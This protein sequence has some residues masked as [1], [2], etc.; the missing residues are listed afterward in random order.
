VQAHEALARRYGEA[1]AAAIA[2]RRK[3]EEAERADATASTKALASGEPLPK[4]KAPPVADRL[5]EAEREVAAVTAL[6]TESALAALAELAPSAGQVSEQAD[7]RAAALEQEALDLLDQA[8]KA[9]TD[10]NLIRA[11]GSWAHE[12][13]LSGVVHPFS[14]RAGSDAGSGA[15]TEAKRAVEWERQRREERRVE[16]ERERETVDMVTVDAASG[17]RRVLP[18]PPGPRWDG[19]RGE[20]VEEPAA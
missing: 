1:Q 2:C 17:Q 9:L 7:E 15:V 18:P 11:E 10:A 16:L 8:L 14:G 20:L 3:L 6:I 5:A 4:A 12:L 13:Y 19:E